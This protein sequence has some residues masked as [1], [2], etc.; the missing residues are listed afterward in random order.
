[1]SCDL[2]Q[3][4]LQCQQKKVAPRE[5][6]RGSATSDGQFCFFAPD[7]SNSVYKYDGQTGKWMK[8]PSCP[9]RDTTLVIIDEKLTAVGGE[10]W[11]NYTNKLLTLK[12]NSNKWAE[13]YPKMQAAHSCPTAVTT[14]DGSH[15]VVIGGYD[16]GG[17]NT[18]VELFQVK[19]RTWYKLVDLPQPLLYPSATICGDQ[20]NVIGTESDVNGY[21]C[22]LQGLLS[23]DLS[24]VTLSWKPLPALPVTHSTTA[25]LSGQLVLVGGGPYESPVSSIH[26]LLDG[27]W[28]KIGSMANARSWCLVANQSPGEIIIVGGRSGYDDL[29]IVEECVVA[30]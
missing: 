13:V 24:R 23:S 15:L 30:F 21:S 12:Q 8:L 1:M 28:V 27:E 6:A 16:D 22:S 7:G 20:L 3:L 29:D 14:S 10:D 11:S 25:T 5:M 9:H 2:P 17:W 4:T 19:S 26:Q 18:R